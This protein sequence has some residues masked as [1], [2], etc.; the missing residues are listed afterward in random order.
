MKTEKEL[1]KLLI[2]SYKGIE[3]ELGIK[4]RNG[5]AIE[6]IRKLAKWMKETTT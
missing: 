4:I 5:Q 6:A 1:D 3:K 2:M